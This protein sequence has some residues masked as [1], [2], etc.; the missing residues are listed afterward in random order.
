MA[1][2]RYGDYIG[3]VFDG[4]LGR[5]PAPHNNLSVE[6]YV[7]TIRGNGEDVYYERIHRD[8]GGYTQFEERIVLSGKRWEEAFLIAKLLFNIPEKLNFP[9]KAHEKE[10]IIENPEKTSNTW[11]DELKILREGTQ[12]LKINYSV[13]RE[14]GGEVIEIKPDEKNNNL[15]I[16]RILI[17]D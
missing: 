8:W 3:Y 16:S 15:V 6:G 17:A 13:R 9:S 14:G 5:F 2:V 4:Y 1:R 10:T 7:Y 12:L 11:N